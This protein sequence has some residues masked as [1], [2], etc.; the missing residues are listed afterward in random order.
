[1]LQA[2][3]PEPLLNEGVFARDGSGLLGEF[4]FVWRL[5]LASRGVDAPVVQRRLGVVAEYQGVHHADRQQRSADEIKRRLVEE[6]GWVFV[7]IWAEDL[8]NLSRQ[9]AMIQRIREGLIP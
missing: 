1:M 6:E 8:T 2:G 4:D 5:P 7:P 3:L 9:F